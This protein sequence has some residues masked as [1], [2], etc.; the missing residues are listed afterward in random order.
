MY[1]DTFDVPYIF[2]LNFS[3]LCI[4]KPGFIPSI[5]KFLFPYMLYTLSLTLDIAPTF[6][7]PRSSTSAAHYGCMHDIIIVIIGLWTEHRG[8][9][10]PL[11]NYQQYLQ[12]FEG[13]RV[14]PAW[15]VPQRGKT[16]LI[17]FPQVPWDRFLWITLLLR[18][19]WIHDILLFFRNL[20]SSVITSKINSN[21]RWKA[22]LVEAVYISVDLRLFVLKGFPFYL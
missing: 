5:V 6:P 16:S 2:R 17:S 13:S 15:P 3:C 14:S 8:S 4:I 20:A 7:N 22:E 21:S 18:A 19:S 9:C 12:E 10:K 11:F 1:V